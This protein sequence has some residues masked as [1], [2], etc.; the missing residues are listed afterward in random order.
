MARKFAQLHCGIWEDPD[1]LALTAEARFTF[2]AC[3]AQKIVNYCGVLVYS[4]ARMARSTGFKPTQVNRALSELHDAGFIFHDADTGEILVRSYVAN[5]GVLNQPQL[6]KAMER[7][8]GDILSEEIKAKVLA[9]L[10][11]TYKG[12]LRPACE[13]PAEQGE[14]EGAARPRITGSVVA[15]TPDVIGNPAIPG[16]PPYEGPTA[17]GKAAARDARRSLR[18]VP[19]SPD[20][21]AGTQRD[22]GARA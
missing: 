12:T 2:V 20:P 8:F 18:S 10:P 9:A 14:D 13:Q 11:D 19:E 1:F 22:A 3:F 4:P 16:S 7:C 6:R 15:T 5:N 17:A 21:L